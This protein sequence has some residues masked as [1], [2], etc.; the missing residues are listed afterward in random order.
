MF[1]EFISFHFGID[2]TFGFEIF[3]SILNYLWFVIICDLWLFV[4]CDYLWFKMNI[5]FKCLTVNL[6][7]NETDD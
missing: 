5:P 7:T 6:L 4:I 3:S 2:T 1:A